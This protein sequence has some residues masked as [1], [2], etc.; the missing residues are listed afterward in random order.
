MARSGENTT[1]DPK[2]NHPQDS[3]SEPC[4]PPAS[5]WLPGSLASA[6]CTPARFAAFLALI[7]LLCFLPVLLGRSTF[8]FRDFGIFGYPLAHHLRESLL[9]GQIP[10]WNPYNSLGLPFLAQWNTLALYPGSVL[11]LVLPLPWSLNLFCLAHL[12]FGGVGMYLLARQWSRKDFAAAVAGLSFSLGG[13]MLCSLKW[14]NNIAVLGW[15]PW[16]IWRAHIAIEKGGT[17][18]AMAACAGA[19]QMLAGTPELILTTWVIIGVLAACRVGLET[20]PWRTILFRGAG[21]T[22]AVAAMCAAQLLPFFDLLRASQ[23]DANFGASSW[24]MPPWGPLNL[25][26]PLLFSFPSHQGVYAQYDQYWIA[27]YYP[28][29]AVVLLAG[30]GCWMLKER[31]VRVLGLALTAFLLL[32]WGDNGWLHPTLVKLVPG[33][34]WMRFPIKFIAPVIALLP[35]CASFAI[36]RLLARPDLLAPRRARGTIAL[37]ALLAVLALG[38]ALAWPM[39]RDTWPQTCLNT[40]LRVA[41]FAVLAWIFQKRIVES[42]PGRARRMEWLV[43]IVLTAD[44]LSHAPW[45]N[46][47]VPSWTAEPKLA[48]LK[49]SPA[50]GSSRAMISPE[51]EWQL[52]HWTPPNP[53]DDYLASRL[54]LFCNCNLLDA[55]PKVD[56]FFSLYPRF[57]AAIVEALYRTPRNAFPNLQRFLGVSAFTTKGKMATWETLPPTPPWLTAGQKPLIVAPGESLHGLLQSSFSPETTVLIDS[58]NPHRVIATN[59]AKIALDDVRWTT[60]SCAGTAR[61][62]TPGWVVVAQSWHPGWHLR[63]DNS[64][65]DLFRAN[66]AFQA[67]QVPA[68]TTHFALTYREPS[69]ATGATISLIGWLFALGIWIRGI[70]IARRLELQDAPA[71]TSRVVRQTTSD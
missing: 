5:R 3:A 70:V 46:P 39:P 44:L 43:L 27:S 50:I 54:G 56:G 22:C 15:M 12:F 47:T 59:A 64:P 35:L 31:S 17:A 4:P 10:F 61:A 63:L 53:T 38:A 60:H 71:D 16:V 48:E 67:F 24:S 41:W 11:Y 13:L 29:A 23:R 7:L 55:I 40:L 34:G 65:A 18:W 33:L 2:P 37:F 58:D 30:L 66:H 25:L 14:P 69:F 62:E 36:A 52:D 51:A 26:F 21:L 68:G 1:P 45:Q 42:D 9:Q 8:Y 20:T 57:S 32:A 28:G 49:P 6:P 19:C